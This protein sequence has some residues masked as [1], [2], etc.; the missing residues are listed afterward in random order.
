M[1]K[2]FLIAVCMVALMAAP[3]F[4][5]G[6]GGFGQGKID[7]DVSAS[8]QGFD[9]DL[10]YD[11]GS[12]TTGIGEAGAFGNTIGKVDGKIFNGKIEGTI[13]IVGGG[14]AG[15][16]HVHYPGGLMSS[17]QAAGNI[18]GK[19]DLSV[20]PKF[21]L[22]VV[23]GSFSGIA[24]QE[25]F[26]T[27]F[28]KNTLGVVAQYSTGSIIGDASV[29][30]SLYQ[31]A[32]AWADAGII[33]TGESFSFSQKWSEN[34]INGART[35]VGA[36]TEVE[37]F[38]F[39]G[40]FNDFCL[41]SGANANVGGNWTAG[42]TALSITEI[43]GAQ[44]TAFGAYSGSGSLNQNYSGEAV[45]FTA[46]QTQTFKGMNGSINTAAAGMSVTSI[47]SRARNLR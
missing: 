5:W 13:E 47:V 4:S 26:N 24:G 34:G 29:F 37:S 3:A 45:G 44:A 9:F 23:C 10:G 11:F 21:G 41:L 2:N 12:R 8:D 33:M 39:V 43:G 40:T 25:T 42:G 16:S 15:S 38:G 31:K 6:G 18:T 1:F 28:N 27:T 17:S 32:G 30:G 46:G 36:W 20:S 14:V 19:L 35:D 7:L 22:G